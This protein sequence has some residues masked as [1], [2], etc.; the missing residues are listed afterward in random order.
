M[1]AIVEDAAKFD[2]DRFLIEL[3]S[4]DNDKK[5]C[6]GDDKCVMMSWPGFESTRHKICCQWQITDLAPGQ[7]PHQPEG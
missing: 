5:Y 7:V 4:Y 3:T 1:A 2:L 6:A